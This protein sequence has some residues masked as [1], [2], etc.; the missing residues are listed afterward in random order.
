MGVEAHKKSAFGLYGKMG[1]GK[2]DVWDW[3]GEKGKAVVVCV[4]LAS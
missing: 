3:Q 2:R 1:K 4:L